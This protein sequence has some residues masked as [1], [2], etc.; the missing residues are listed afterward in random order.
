MLRGMGWHAMYAYALITGAYL[1]SQT[2]GF[3]E[4]IAGVIVGVLANEVFR[5]SRARL[6]NER[7]TNS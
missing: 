6:E 4:F 3:T 1:V 5:F 2:V 7:R